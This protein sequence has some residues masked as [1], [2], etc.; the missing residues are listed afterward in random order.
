[1]GVLESLV[2]RMRAI[3]RGGACDRGWEE[4]LDRLGGVWPGVG[5]K[6]SESVSEVN[7]GGNSGGYVRT[8]WLGVD[9]AVGGL[10]LG[11]V[12]EWF[13][14]GSWCGGEGLEASGWSP[15]LCVLAHL[16]CRSLLRCGTG[17]GSGAP[18]G[19]VVWIGRRCWPH[20]RLLERLGVGLASSC[21]ASS[22]SKGAS[23][24]LAGAISGSFPGAI[25]AAI[26]GTIPGA[27]S[28]LGLP[29]V[30]GRSYFVDVV[31]DADRLWAMDL[32]LRCR[33]VS[34]VVGDGSGLDM[35]ASRRL[36]LAARFGGGLG[37]IARPRN[38]LSE[39]S[40]ASTRWL[41]EPMVATT[42]RPRWSL[43]LLRRKGLGTFRGPVRR[44]VGVPE[45]VLGEVS[46]RSIGL[47]G[48]GAERVEGVGDCSDQPRWTVELDYET[49]L[50]G[51]PAELADRSPEASPGFG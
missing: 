24:V 49:G 44:A 19:G 47:S 36:Q 46:E 34:V 11:G 40:A 10:M 18:S 33:S 16:A 32:A 9:A 5:G 6:G 38:E 35:A 31:R 15:P 37:L 50:V 45:P 17:E 26:P 2:D 43:T 1:M 51:V 21:S 7:C 23:G 42:E 22:A 30:L 41:V 25:P 3:E 20:V 48:E 29:G 13:G 27:G 8:G 28:V 4:A 14:W 12:H 39:L